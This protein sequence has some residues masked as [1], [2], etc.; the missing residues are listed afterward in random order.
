MYSHF[1]KNGDYIG[2]YMSYKSQ[3]DLNL[4]KEN[5]EDMG[6]SVKDTDAPEK[7]TDEVLVVDENAPTVKQEV[8]LNNNVYTILVIDETCYESLNDVATILS[9]DNL[10]SE[11]AFI[12]KF[13]T[14]VQVYFDAKW[15]NVSDAK[16]HYL[17]SLN[18]I[19]NKTLDFLQTIM[20]IDFALLDILQLIDE[21]YIGSPSPRKYISDN[22]LK[23]RDEITNRSEEHT[24]E[25]KEQT[26]EKDKNA[27]KETEN[28]FDE[29][30]NEEEG[31]SVSLD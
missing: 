15:K 4:A 5:A 26:L 19:Q 10:A 9:I 25:H 13:T 1:T 31:G 29:A 20:N 11:L 27:K 18:N 24:K 23:F 21:Q 7:T 16:D 3:K 22:V 14:S 30:Q 2:G 28:E 17:K 6:K 12:Q 8:D